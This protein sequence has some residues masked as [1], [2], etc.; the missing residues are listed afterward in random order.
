MAKIQVFNNICCK[1]VAKWALSKLQ[2]VYE[3]LT[4]LYGGQYSNFSQNYICIWSFTEKFHFGEFIL[5]VHIY[6]CVK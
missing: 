4:T 2:V 1:V 3:L 5:Q 6:M